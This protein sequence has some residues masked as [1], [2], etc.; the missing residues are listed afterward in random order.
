MYINNRQQAIC[1]TIDAVGRLKE[2]KLSPY[3]KIRITKPCNPDIKSKK[4]T[5]FKVEIQSPLSL[6]QQI[7]LNKNT[8]L[9]RVEFQR[10]KKNLK[11][12]SST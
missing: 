5:F 4:I 7:N 1:V 10:D 3:V 11:K 6:P 2:I 12:P 9:F 8:F